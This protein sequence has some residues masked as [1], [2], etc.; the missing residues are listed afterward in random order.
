MGTSKNS[1]GYTVEDYY[2]AMTAAWNNWVHNARPRRPIA[3]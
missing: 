2:Q 1:Q 3:Q